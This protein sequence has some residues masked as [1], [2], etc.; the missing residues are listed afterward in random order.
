MAFSALGCGVF[1]GLVSWLYHM[2]LFDALGLAHQA[3]WPELVAQYGR[4]SMLAAGVTAVATSLFI[5]VVSTFSFHRIV[6]PVLNLKQHIIAVTN[7]E[8]VQPLCFRATDQLSDVS[9]LYNRMMVA[10]DVLDEEKPDAEIPPS[11]AMASTTP[12]EGA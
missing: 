8:P 3:G 2:Q 12:T 11:S 5:T 1:V 7:G 4:L 6:G 9:D 10:L